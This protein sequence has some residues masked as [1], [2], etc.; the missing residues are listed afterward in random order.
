MAHHMIRGL[1]KKTAFLK[2]FILSLSGMFCIP[3]WIAD[4]AI[5]GTKNAERNQK[6]AKAAKVHK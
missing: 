2:I 5:I 3:N 6:V 1:W 4:S